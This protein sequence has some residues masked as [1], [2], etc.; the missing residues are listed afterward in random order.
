ME[1]AM[2]LVW[3]LGVVW[4]VA[5]AGVV[6]GL[7]PLG[8]ISEAVRALS[9]RGKLK[10]ATSVQS[11]PRFTVPQRWFTHFYVLG[12]LVNTILLAVAFLFAYM[13]TF[14]LQSHESKVSAMVFSMS[15][16]GQTHA[17][18]VGVDNVPQLAKYRERAWSSFL[19]LAMLEIHLLRRLF[20]SVYMFHYSPLARMHILGYFA[21]L[22]FYP[23]AS[24]TFFTVHFQDKDYFSALNTFVVQRIGRFLILHTGPPLLNFELGVQ[25]YV[26]GFQGLQAFQW[27]GLAIFLLG[28]IQQYRL[29]SIL[30]SLRA[31]R[32]HTG[33]EAVLKP[34]SMDKKRADRYEIPLGS[35]F[36]WVSCAHYLAEIV[37][38]LG[39]LIASGGNNLNVWLCFTWVVLNLTFGA[40]EMHKWYK[41]KFE[42]YP[43]SRYAIFPFIY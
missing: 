17:A 32:V 43:T 30:A 37:I 10:L 29:H 5:S 24:I 13:C 8:A 40:S 41:T 27:V 2:G 25:D 23:G 19:L 42:D 3:G 18:S 35:W 34:F 6:L 1:W 36:E 15:G 31:K 16:A 38:F 22:G 21:G 39:I 20:E 4:S 12:I 11:P 14:P 28:S 33:V 9:R 26:K 7:L